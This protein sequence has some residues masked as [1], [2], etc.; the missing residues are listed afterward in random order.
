[1]EEKTVKEKLPV[2]AR[3]AKRVK[4]FHGRYTP[5]WNAWSPT[6]PDL[7]GRRNETCH[8]VA[9]CCRGYKVSSAILY[10]R[11]WYHILRNAFEF[12][13]ICPGTGFQV[14]FCDYLIISPPYDMTD[15]AQNVICVFLWFRGF[16][17]QCIDGFCTCKRIGDLCRTT[18]DCCGDTMISF[19]S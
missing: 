10:T 19:G 11:Y 14:N 2:L 9:G 18:S 3:A 1:M 16:S 4:D 6:P 17:I 15:T 7:C 12:F 5:G 13:W 8:P